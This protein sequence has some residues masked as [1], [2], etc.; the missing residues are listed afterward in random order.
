M[1]PMVNK[2][3]GG[4]S[5]LTTNIL[6]VYVKVTLEPKELLAPNV[7]MIALMKLNLV[8]YGV[9]DLTDIEEDTH[10]IFVIVDSR[11]NFILHRP[12]MQ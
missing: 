3:D 10:G 2:L 6:A 12:I 9:E 8:T 5:F 1:N 11:S 4:A 7:I